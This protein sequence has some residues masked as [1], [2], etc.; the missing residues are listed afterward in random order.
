MT[1]WYATENVKDYF[2]WN[3]FLWINAKYFVWY[4]ELW[5][6]CQHDLAHILDEVQYYLNIYFFSQSPSLATLKSRKSH[7]VSPKL[8]SSM[9]PVLHLDCPFFLL[10]RLAR[11]LSVPS[12]LTQLRFTLFLEAKKSKQQQQPTTCCTVEKIFKIFLKYHEKYSSF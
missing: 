11:D 5:E 7:Q 3:N 4:H 12:P 1:K 2:L 9:L 8:I 6:N 10:V